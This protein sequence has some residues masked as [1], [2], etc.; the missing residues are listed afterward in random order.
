MWSV[1]SYFM[2]APYLELICFT[3]ESI[4]ETSIHWNANHG[5][6]L[7]FCA[8]FFFFVISSKLLSS[9]N[10]NHA[11][12]DLCYSYRCLCELAKQIGFQDQA[13][14]IFQL[15]QQL[16][17]FRHVVSTIRLFFLLAD[18]NTKNENSTP[19]VAATGNGPTRYQIRTIFEHCNEI[20]VSFSAYG[21]CGC[22]RT[23][24]RW[25]TITHSGYSG[26]NFG[27][28]Y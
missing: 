17:T 12:V 5:T 16:S 23:N 3:A 10:F 28:L 13:Q 8:T 18:Y 6:L 4:Y 27:F 2:Y 26:Y 14:N 9:N 1:H 7:H 15:E 24:W 22:Q 19:S 20:K 25:L 21:R 11:K